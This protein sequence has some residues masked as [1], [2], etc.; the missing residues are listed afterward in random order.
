MIK[1]DIRPFQKGD[2]DAMLTMESLFC[3]TEMDKLPEQ[4]AYTARHEG[5]LLACAGVKIYW[6]GVGEAWA[7]ISPEIVNYKREL[8]HYMRKYI[9]HIAE[10][11]G[12]WRI[13]VV[14]RK[15]FPQGLRLA[16]HLGFEMEGKMEKYGTDGVDCFLFSR[17]F[18]CAI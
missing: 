10:T 4:P 1:L 16:R 17:I 12:L 5:K 9:A 13:Q 3:R 8:L 11:E 14:V 15:D 7:F 18:E 6:P 2:A